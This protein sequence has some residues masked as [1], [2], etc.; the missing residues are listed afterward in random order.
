MNIMLFPFDKQQCEFIFGSWTYTMNYLNYTLFDSLFLK[1]FT[2]NNEWIL[3]DFKG[4]RAE[5][6]LVIS[7][8]IENW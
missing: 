5:I 4:K 6:K 2:E 7:V 8:S 1:D 3:I